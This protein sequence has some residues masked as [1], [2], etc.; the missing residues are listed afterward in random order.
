M[1]TVPF[2]QDERVLIPQKYLGIAL[3]IPDDK[4]HIFWDGATGTATL[5]TTAGKEA[6][7]STGSMILIF[8][9]KNIQMDVEPIAQDG[10]IFLPARFLTEAMGGSVSWNDLTKTVTVK[11]VR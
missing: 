2:V 8:D 5:V 4:D 1:D 10:H 7:C 6:R 11:I 3:G 9:G